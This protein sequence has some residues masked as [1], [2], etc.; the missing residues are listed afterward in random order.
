[1]LSLKVVSYSLFLFF[2]V[3]IFLMLKNFYN[4]LYIFEDVE[5]T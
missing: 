4:I 5:V 3:C 1:M 2:F